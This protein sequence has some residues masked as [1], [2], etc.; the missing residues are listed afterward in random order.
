MSL[1]NAAPGGGEGVSAPV[2]VVTP[3][4]DTASYSNARDAARDLIAFRNK[5]PESQAAPAEGEPAVEQPQ[6]L[7][8]EANAAPHEDGA[9]GETQEIDPAAEPSIEPP[10]SWTKEEKERFSSLPRE[11]QEYLANREQERDRAVRQSQNEAA[12]HRKAL[13]AEK[14]VVAQARQQ[15]E[16][17]LPALLQTLQEQQA[18]EFS[19]IRTMADVERLAREDWPRYALWDAQQ[20]KVAAVTQEVN[21]AYERQSHEFQQR[22]S[23]FSKT[24]DAKLLEREPEIADPEKASKLRE[25]AFNLLRQDIG[26]NEQELG[27]LWN[28]AASLSIRDHR[29]QRLILKAAKYDE[30]T[31]AAKTAVAKPL[32]PVQRP[33]AAP[34]KGQARQ[35]EVQTLTQRLERTG[36]MRDAAK[37]LAARRAAAR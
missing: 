10:R 19:D 4:T 30:A 26:F 22:W 18:G 20:K 34:V 1:D 9:P 13:E 21:A 27:D 15:Y 37:L 3:A 25:S 24:E 35:E 16:A 32:A 17:A 7:A 2:T 33:G 23:D 31:K 11:T 14:S 12:E 28:G 6:E 36:N 5:K 29:V 8:E